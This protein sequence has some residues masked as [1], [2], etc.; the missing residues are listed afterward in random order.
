MADAG[1]HP[2]VVGE[3]QHVRQLLRLRVGRRG[4]GAEH[5][6]RRVDAAA[7]HHDGGDHQVRQQYFPRQH[8]VQQY[9]QLVPE[10]QHRRCAR[11]RRGSRVPPTWTLGGRSARTSAVAWFATSCGSTTG[12]TRSRD[13]EDVLGAFK[14]DGTPA[15]DDK[16]SVWFNAKVSYQ[17]SKNHKL[18]GFQQLQHKGAIRNVTQFVPWE[19]RVFQDLWGVTAKG[20][21]QA[22]WS[23]SLVTNVSA[24][25]W[26]WHSPFIG[27][28]DKPS[29]LRRHDAEVH[30][31][32]HWQRRSVRG[33]EG[34][35]SHE[36]G[37]DE[38]VPPRPFP[39]QSR[40][41]GRLRLC[42]LLHRQVAR[43]ARG[44]RRLSAEL[45]ERRAVPGGHLQ[46][47][48]QS[49]CRRAVTWGCT[50]WTTG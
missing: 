2:H 21:W 1:R 28:T 25:I 39:R 34:A 16:L 41:Q 14:P 45:Q 15:V 38:L 4:P 48:R 42:R 35:E 26:Q 7:W 24:G 23:S 13:K 9:V 32:D 46:F 20:E 19:S 49:P 27:Q 17:A 6:R 50:S 47:S 36:Q 12:V 29:T 44:G 31:P 22:V 43:V 8:V 33:S 40:V 18:V 5:R 30:R 10:Q 37:N 3:D 11:R